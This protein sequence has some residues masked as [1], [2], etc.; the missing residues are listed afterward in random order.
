VHF[1]WIVLLGIVGLQ[2]TSSRFTSACVVLLLAARCVEGVRIEERVDQPGNEG[3]DALTNVSLFADLHLFT[4]EDVL[5]L[6]EEEAV[7]VEGGSWS[8]SGWW[9]RADEPSSMREE[10]SQSWGGRRRRR[11]VNTRRRRRF[12]KAVV[13]HAKAFR[14]LG[15]GIVTGKGSDAFKGFNKHVVCSIAVCEGLCPLLDEAKKLEDKMKFYVLTRMPSLNQT[16]LDEEAKLDARKMAGNHPWDCDSDVQGNCSASALTDQNR[17]TEAKTQAAMAVDTM[18]KD[19]DTASSKIDSIK[20][21]LRRNFWTKVCKT[22]LDSLNAVVD[23]VAELIAKYRCE[24]VE[25]A[26]IAASALVDKLV[27]VAVVGATYGAGGYIAALQAQPFCIAA[28]MG[29]DKLKKLGPLT[30]TVTT[31]VTRTVGKALCKI[32]MSQQIKDTFGDDMDWKACA[33][34]SLSLNLF[35]CGVNLYCGQFANAINSLLL[36]LIMCKLKLRPDGSQCRTSCL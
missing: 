16:L 7:I 15:H 6:S 22:F 9:K 11:S 26:F 27:M 28:A 20:L 13:S 25:L 21:K 14:D 12:F 3:P 33:V 1:Y 29:V 17:Q 5:V 8:S 4:D 18:N 19:I 34:T 32:P 30:A 36:P 2:M 31:A 10:G 24:M 23:K 35:A